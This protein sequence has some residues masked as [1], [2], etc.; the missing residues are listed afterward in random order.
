MMFNKLVKATV[1][2]IT[3]MVII[4][5]VLFYVGETINFI[6]WKSSGVIGTGFNFEPD[7]VVT[8][9]DIGDEDF[10]SK[11]VP[12]SGDTILAIDGYPASEEYLRDTL[13]KPHPPGRQI[14]FKY[15]HDSDTS[16]ATMESKASTNK[17]VIQFLLLSILRLLIVLSFIG[18]G[19]WAFV[20]RPDSNPVRALLLFSLAM[21]SIVITA[22]TFGH[23][24][25][26]LYS[27]IFLSELFPYLNRIGL[28]FGAFWLNLQLLFPRPRKIIQNHPIPVYLAI[29]LPLPAVLVAGNYFEF[30]N[31]ILALLGLTVLVQVTIGF[32][33]LARYHIKTKNSLEKRQTRLV[34]WGTG[35]GLAVFFLIIIIAIA[36]G[37]WLTGLGEFYRVGLLI[38]MLFGLLLSPISFAY[39]FGRY[40]LLE[41]EGRIKRGTRYAAVTVVLLIVFYLTIYGVSEFLLDTIGIVDR[42]PALLVA[43]FL[44]IGFIPAQQK[45]Q[46]FAE[47][48]IYPE[49]NR[50]KRMLRDFLEQ[51]QTFTEQETFWI[52]LEQKLAESLKID[53]VYPIMYF[54]KADKFYHWREK[55]ELPFK[56]DSAFIK[57]LSGLK[58]HPL[59]LDEAEASERF[60]IAYEEEQWLNDRHIAM[61]LPLVTR[62]RL[63]GFLALP[64]SSDKGDFKAEDLSVL[65]SLAS[66][67]AVASENMVLIEENINKRRLEHELGMARKVQ[68]RLF[69]E[70]LPET[71]GLDVGAKSRFCLEVAGDYYDV[72]KLDDSRTVLTVGDVSGKG[73]GAA[74]IMSNL[75]ASLKTALKI[76]NELAEIVA[77]INDLIFENTTQDQ[78]IT[79]FVGVFD[80]RESVF[81]YVNAGHNPPVVIRDN[82]KIEEL[83]E[84]GLLL[85][86]FPNAVYE[87]GSVVLN[88]GDLL[89][90]YTD[91]VSEAENN[92]NDMYGE[93]RIKE[94][95]AANS[96]LPASELLTNLESDVERFIGDTSFDDDFTLVAA[97]VL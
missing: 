78:F 73:A 22:I 44:A 3:S 68:E 16:V 4:T 6:N 91:G 10:V 75:Q 5:V 27:N 15:I 1:I 29:Y 88:K 17:E 42:G 76:K 41:I 93:E 25:I 77:Q 84:G 18:V 14:E 34:L 28:M 54:E 26:D 39:S 40:R 90:L 20:K 57:E 38:I 36:A 23:D 59:M 83:G 82:G 53:T 79:F 45:I 43:L 56:P 8:F 63:I 67:V 70:K 33:I 96:R 30:G 66:Q 47:D 65:M 80:N 95:L 52:Q 97:R 35:I 64:F 71:P 89:F 19:L 2:L 37:Q 86:A 31:T 50:L 87:Q 55:S 72:I 11:P 12:D 51:G 85:G 60:D 24:Q 48:K 69:P 21:A 94:F 32:V 81:T 61:I 58:N 62:S 46:T 13:F 7:S 49:R 9:A 92:V 74:L